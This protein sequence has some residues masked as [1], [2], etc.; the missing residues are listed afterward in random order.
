MRNL[1]RMNDAR[2]QRIVYGII[3]QVESLWRLAK[4]KRNGVMPMLIFGFTPGKE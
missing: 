2:V 1:L 4:P 3:K